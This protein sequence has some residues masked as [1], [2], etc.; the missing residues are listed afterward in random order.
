[1]SPFRA[2]N[3]AWV[4]LRSVIEEQ[5]V[6]ETADQLSAK[7]PRFD[8]AWDAL[9]WLLAREPNQKNAARRA[10]GEPPTEYMV[11]IQAGD[12]I[13]RT[14]DIWVLYTYTIDVVRIIS[15]NAVE[16]QRDDE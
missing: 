7:F 3:V 4:V 12:R 5:D 15:I 14:P 8:D 9:T 16:P 1:M 13:A 11:Y 6:S 2:R 10:I